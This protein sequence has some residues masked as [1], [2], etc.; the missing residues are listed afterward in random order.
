M[1]QC[2]GRMHGYGI[3]IHTNGRRYEGEFRAGRKEV[4]VSQAHLLNDIRLTSF[5]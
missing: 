2:S 1:V 3:L 5:D 4:R